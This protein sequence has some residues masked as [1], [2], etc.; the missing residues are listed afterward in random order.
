MKS[1]RIELLIMAAG[2]IAVFGL[3]LTMSAVYGITET[4]SFTF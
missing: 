1:E 3:V 4:G 2:A